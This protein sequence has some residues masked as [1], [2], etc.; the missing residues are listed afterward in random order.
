MKE[1]AVILFIDL[2]YP[3][4]NQKNFTCESNITTEKQ[5]EVIREFLRSQMGAGRDESKPII[6]DEYHI[7]L[8]LDL[9]NDSFTCQH[10]TGNKGLREGILM[11]V[12]RL[13]DEKK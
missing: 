5:A 6:K 4:K 3:V 1:K 9:S 10:D 7:R 11:Q 12:A 13:M 8:E 2:K